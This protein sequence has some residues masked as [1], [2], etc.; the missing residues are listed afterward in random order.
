MKTGTNDVEDLADRDC[1]AL[2]SPLTT[3]IVRSLRDDPNYTKC[4]RC[5][6]FHAVRLNYEG[7]CDRC[8]KVL[9]ED[10]PNHE[11]V[12]GIVA[13]REAQRQQFSRKAQ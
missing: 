9:I 10:W 2:L 13:S 7:L 12:P 8:C 1:E 11:S 6:H 5:W 4:P 3:V